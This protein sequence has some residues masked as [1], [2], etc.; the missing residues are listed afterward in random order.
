MV[1]RTSGSC[2]GLGVGLQYVLAARS[3]FAVWGLLLVAAGLLVVSTTDSH[4]AGS[5]AT[6]ERVWRD[7][8]HGKSPFRDSFN[9]VAA[10]SPYDVWAV[11]NDYAGHWNGIAWSYVS[12]ARANGELNDVAVASNGEA[13]AVGESGRH[14][15]IEH[16][17]GRAWQRM[18]LSASAANPRRV[19][20]LGTRTLEAIAIRSRTDVWAVG[21]DWRH[22]TKEQYRNGI[23]IHP[24]ELGV[25]LHWDG[26]IW[27]RVGL[28]ARAVWEH[29]FHDVTVAD[30]TSVWV[31]GAGSFAN[32]YQ[33]I[34][35]R[36]DRQRW[37][38]FGLRA[39]SGSDFVSLNAVT[40][41]GGR[42]V[43]AVGV[44]STGPGHLTGESWGLVFRFNGRRWSA[45]VPDFNGSYS[46]YDAVAART[47]RGVW[48][49]DNDTDPFNQAAG[50]A[51]FAALHPARWRRMQ[52]A[53][54]EI[55]K[56]LAF[57]GR[58]VWAVGGTGR[59][60]R[61]PNDYDYARF[62]PLIER[63]GC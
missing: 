44:A 20:S 48:I 43:M 37:K 27:R 34:A 57:D 23:F 8:A 30:D 60:R 4:A 16:W 46:S 36:L 18:P 31:V 24:E 38:A 19:G 63:Y 28:S 51:L 3:R 11:G 62:T 45:R 40:G 14:A 29:D 53:Q 7:V 55:I 17:D 21:A 59:G 9:A 47:P 33:G 25:V 12:V 13:W 39:P 22:Y 41:V 32:P 2:N 15:L 56:S 10:R 6:C 35:L 5:S 49:A 50:T 58:D 52:L 54:G 61:D 42:E 26:H 1:A